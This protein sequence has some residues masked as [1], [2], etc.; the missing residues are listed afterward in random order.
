MGAITTP[1]SA[2][3]YRTSSWTNSCSSTDTSQYSHGSSNVIHIGSKPTS[4]PSGAAQ[5]PGR[6]PVE[7]LCP[8]GC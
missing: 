3:I 1:V 2:T 4:T 8:Q 6:P 5:C 7:D